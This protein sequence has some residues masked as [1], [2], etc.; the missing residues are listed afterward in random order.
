MP[1]T[2][3]A[4]TTTNTSEILSGEH[5]CLPRTPDILTDKGGFI[6]QLLVTVFITVIIYSFYV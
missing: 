5:K 4:G 2:V 3:H 6:A 1:A